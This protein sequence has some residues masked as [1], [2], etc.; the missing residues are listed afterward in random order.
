MDLPAA[1]CGN[2]P[3]A[4]ALEPLRFHYPSGSVCGA[5]T[6]QRR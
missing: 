1:G 2:R 4:S 5:Y 6:R 3:A